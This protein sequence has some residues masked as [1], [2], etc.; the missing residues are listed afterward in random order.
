MVESEICNVEVGKLLS[1][2][3]FLLSYLGDG[4]IQPLNEMNHKWKSK[5]LGEKDGGT[6]ETIC[7]LNL[8]LQT[9]PREEAKIIF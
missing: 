6:S 4:S 9:G 1:L 5:E 3:V 8:D 2:P 7:L